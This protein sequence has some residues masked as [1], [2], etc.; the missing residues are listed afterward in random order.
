M[1]KDAQSVGMMTA[2]HNYL[3]T[4]MVGTRKLRIDFVLIPNYDLMETKTI[5][6]I[7]LHLFPFQTLYQSQF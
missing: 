3:I 6:N 4:N 7:G 2:Y 1:L 5:T